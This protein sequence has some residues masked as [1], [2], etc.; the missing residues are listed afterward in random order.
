M[1]N[2]LETLLG[3]QHT[4]V[5]LQEPC[6]KKQSGWPTLKAQR[7]KGKALA[8]TSSTKRD[9]PAFEIVEERLERSHKKQGVTND[10]W[11]LVCKRKGHL[12]ADCPKARLRVGGQKAHGTGTME[13]V[14]S[15]SSGFPLNKGKGKEV[16]FQV[17]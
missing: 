10:T 5:Q 7:A 14:P 15:S 6:K 4:V 17:S 3:G 16:T 11:F 1:I 2:Q 8:A 9:P 13:S 12:R